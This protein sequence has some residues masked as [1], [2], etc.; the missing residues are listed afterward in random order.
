MVVII[1]VAYLHRYSLD[2]NNGKRLNDTERRTWKNKSEKLPMGHFPWTSFKFLYRHECSG[3][4][5]FK[6][7]IAD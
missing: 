3:P 1:R 4:Q 5:P 2:L 6:Q 7:Y